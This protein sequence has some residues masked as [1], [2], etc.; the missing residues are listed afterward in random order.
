MFPP[1]NHVRS[2]GK[3]PPPGPCF[4]C[5]SPFHWN[6]DCPHWDEYQERRSKES[7]SVE[8]DAAGQ[9]A[10][11]SAYT[12]IVEQGFD[13][14]TRTFPEEREAECKSYEHEEGGEERKEEGE[15]TRREVFIAS[16]PAFF[17]RVEEIAEEYW[18]CGECL[19]ADSLYD[20]EY[21]YAEAEEEGKL[22]GRGMRAEINRVEESEGEISEELRALK[23][24]DPPMIRLRPR[25]RAAR[26]QRLDV[27]VL[28]VRGRIGSKDDP[29]TDLRLDSGANLT[30]V[31]GRY[32]DSSAHPRRITQ[33]EPMQLQQ[34]TSKDT[35]IRGTTQMEISIEA[36]DGTP[37]EM[38]WD[39]YVVD[40]MTVDVLL[41]E[42]FQQAFGVSVSRAIGAEGERTEITFAGA[43]EHP[44]TAGHFKR[45]RQ[46]RRQQKE[47]AR[48][49][50]SLVR[51]DQDVRLP[52]HTCVK[53]RVEGPFSKDEEWVVEKL[54]LA[55]T[56]DQLLAVP[57]TILSTD[58][59]YV[60]IANPSDTPR[61]VR[62]GDVVGRAYRAD[63][64]FDSPTSRD[65]KSRW[66]EHAAR[67]ASLVELQSQ[68]GT[69][70]GK[71]KSAR[72][73]TMDPKRRRC[74]TPARSRVSSFGRY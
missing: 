69:P 37:I 74:P 63:K 8:L 65:E 72:T 44:V 34:L 29:V 47:K 11:D 39:V 27:S 31:S 13:E 50:D 49:A 24:Y 36:D 22:E 28:N 66:E 57:N 7:F 61:I 64:F 21:I 23:P 1:A 59:P 71:S 54:I 10:Y 51:A 62:K 40:G 14:A 32:Y 46:Q 15:V 68:E 30:L 58:D 48:I 53:I 70:G 55:G 33:G 73:R 52:P 18:H 4:A 43:A 56:A 25:K 9:A 16:T 60:P 12:L 20:L 38:D 35:P 2:K 45:I 5:G 67:I 42:D 3:K 17:E 26:G 19:P 6:K 41:G